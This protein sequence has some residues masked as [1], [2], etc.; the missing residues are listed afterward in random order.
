M[1]MNC[2]LVKLLLKKKPINTQ[3][4]KTVGEITEDRRLPKKCKLESR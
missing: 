3:R 1:Y 4:E 2:I